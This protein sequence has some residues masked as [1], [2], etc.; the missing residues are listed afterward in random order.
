MKKFIFAALLIFAAT[1]ST[2]A[3]PRTTGER[4]G[5]E[6]AG[7]HAL[8]C[9]QIIK[10]LQLDSAKSESFRE[11][12]MDYNEAIKALRPAAN[13]S[14]ERPNEAPTEEQIEES[15]L[16]SFDM[17]IKTMEI[18]REYYM[19]FRE[20]LTPS[21]INTMYRTERNIRDRAIEELQQRRHNGGGMNNNNGGNRPAPPRF[22]MGE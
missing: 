20:I 15:T 16:S 2:T 12:Y 22:N 3:Q 7:M 13:R 19:K 14:V 4:G 1:F 9:N 8:Q 21:Q 5:G 17:S 10:V 18:K 6:N 11:I